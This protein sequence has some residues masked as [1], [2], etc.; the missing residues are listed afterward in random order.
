MPGVSG[1]RGSLSGGQ[2]INDSHV[3]HV[4]AMG[5]MYIIHASITE[6]SSVG[7]SPCDML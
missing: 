5:S 4:G 3:R 2:T 7:H 1:G 6:V